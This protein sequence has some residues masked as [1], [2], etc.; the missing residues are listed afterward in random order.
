MEHKKLTREQLAKIDRAK[1][2]VDKKVYRADSIVQVH[3]D[4]EV[5]VDSKE[6]KAVEKFARKFFKSI[7]KTLKERDGE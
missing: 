6:I 2:P 3:P 5:T 1:N 7:D 4:T